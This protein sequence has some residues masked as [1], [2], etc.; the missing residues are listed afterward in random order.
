[1]NGFGVALLALMAGIIGDAPP[2]RETLTLRE[3]R[4][5]STE[6][7]AGRVLGMSGQAM[8][9]AKVWPGAPVFDSPSRL[10]S[11]EFTSG[12]GSAGWSDLCGATIIRVGFYPIDRDVPSPDPP[13]IAG[14]PDPHPVWSVLAP[15]MRSTEDQASTDPT[16]KWT[17]EQAR[18]ASLGSV[19]TGR[20][21]GVFFRARIEQRDM[22]ALE[23]S[24][25][26]SL[27][28]SL[29]DP[30]AISRDRVNCRLAEPDACADPVASLARIDARRPAAV[31]VKRCGPLYANI[32]VEAEY[33]TTDRTLGEGRFTL[34]SVQTTASTLYTTDYSIDQVTIERRGWV[35]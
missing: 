13:S 27:L 9:E 19:L 21:K 35:V 20:D 16:A 8:R 7:L 5:L 26:V 22:T 3:A 25:L 18:C 6:Q 23:M 4:T 17:R 34:V 10:S 15:S 28:N 24:F 31:A 30:R 14:S 33:E 29:D 1:M 32:C 12:G 11:I 2:G